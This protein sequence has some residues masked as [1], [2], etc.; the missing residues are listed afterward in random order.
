MDTIIR[1]A[2]RLTYFDMLLPGNVG[3]DARKAKGTGSF[4]LSIYQ[5]FPSVD[6]EPSNIPLLCR[7]GRGEEV[8]FGEVPLV[9]FARSVRSKL[10]KLLSRLVH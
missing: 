7:Q 3:M 8:D 5:T 9:L 4:F 10:V 6:S 1:L 2:R